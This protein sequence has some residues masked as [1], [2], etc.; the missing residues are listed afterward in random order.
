MPVINAMSGAD[1]GNFT[2]SVSATS[3]TANISSISFTNTSAQSWQFEVHLGS[4][5]APA[6]NFEIEGNTSRTVSANE[7]RQVF[8]RNVAYDEFYWNMNGVG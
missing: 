2:L 1:G 8:G 6:Q 3:R 4:W 7:L 5:T